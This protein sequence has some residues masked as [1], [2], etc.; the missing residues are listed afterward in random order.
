MRAAVNGVLIRQSYLFQ[1]YK[2]KVGAFDQ[3]NQS[4]ISGQTL[5]YEE[6]VTDNWSKARNT[7]SDPDIR[8][9]RGDDG[10]FRYLLRLSVLRAADASQPVELFVILEHDY[11]AND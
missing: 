7:G 4:V 10:K 5:G 3:D 8:F 2:L 11:L 1:H 9:L 6:I